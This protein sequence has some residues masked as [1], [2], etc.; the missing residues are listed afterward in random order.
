MQANDLST[1]SELR[2]GLVGNG[3]GDASTNGNDPWG[4]VP[5]KFEDEW[6]ARHN[7]ELWGAGPDG[8]YRWR[9]QADGFVE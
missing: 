4:P 2:I 7:E 9:D 3:G 1:G 8:T 6:A 5:R